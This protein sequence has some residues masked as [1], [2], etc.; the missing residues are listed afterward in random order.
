VDR[1]RSRH[2]ARELFQVPFDVIS[3]LGVGTRMREQHTLAVLDIGQAHAARGIGIAADEATVDAEQIHLAQ[4]REAWDLHPS[5]E[6]DVP[7]PEPET[8]LCQGMDHVPRS[9]CPIRTEPSIL[10][11]G[12]RPWWRASPHWR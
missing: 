12:R 2:V 3:E 7:E 10:E 1:P 8:H 6:A 4:E 9:R 11:P 5:N